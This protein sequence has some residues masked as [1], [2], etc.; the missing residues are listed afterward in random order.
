MRKEDGLW[1]IIAQ[2]MPEWVV[3]NEST[4]HD[5][6]EEELNANPH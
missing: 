1:K 2:P 5:V 3:K 6:I 4:F